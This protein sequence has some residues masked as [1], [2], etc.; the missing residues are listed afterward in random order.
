LRNYDKGEFWVVRSSAAEALAKIGF[1][2][3]ETVPALIDTLEDEDESVR[4]R[5]AEALGKIGPTAKEAVPTLIDALQDQDESVR[6]RAAEALGEI[7]PTAKEAVPALIEA[8]QDEYVRYHAALALAKIGENLQ[9]A[10][11][12]V[13]DNLKTHIGCN[14]ESISE[15]LGKIGKNAVPALI[16]VLKDKDWSVRWVAAR[17]LGKISADAKE[18]VPELTE[19]FL[20]RNENIRIRFEAMTALR[21]IGSEQAISVVN[22]YKKTADSISNWIVIHHFNVVCPQAAT[23]SVKQATTASISKQPV[24]CKIPAIRAVLKWKCL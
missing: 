11:P 8:L 21:N 14:H 23:P 13:I 16:A 1:T 18:A 24:M 4:S 15:D 12:V 2:T 3:E 7:G 9:D 20:D 6:S 5:A 10:M 22:R 19:I 17:A